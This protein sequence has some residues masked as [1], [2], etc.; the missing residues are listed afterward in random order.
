MK[1]V[2]KE[3]LFLISGAA[4]LA[5]LLVARAWTGSPGAAAKAAF[6]IINPGKKSRSQAVAQKNLTRSP[7]FLTSEMVLGRQRGSVHLLGAGR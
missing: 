1:M 4:V 3:Q 6:G 2:S 5:L 7:P